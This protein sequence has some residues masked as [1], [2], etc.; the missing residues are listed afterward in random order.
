MKVACKDNYPTPVVLLTDCLSQKNYLDGLL[1]L[2]VS[3]I[4]ITRDQVLFCNYN[5]ILSQIKN[6]SVILRRRVEVIVP[7]LETNVHRC[8]KQHFHG[9]SVG[10]WWA[11]SIASLLSCAHYSVIP[12]SSLQNERNSYERNCFQRSK[13]WEVFLT[14]R[15]MML[16]PKCLWIHQ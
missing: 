16:P 8:I 12:M 7:I 14:W 1:S 10:F 4:K 9:N 15:K 11:L 2:R 13:I 6:L 5:H 3:S